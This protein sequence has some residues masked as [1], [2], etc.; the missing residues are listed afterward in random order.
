MNLFEKCGFGPTYTSKYMIVVRSTM[1]PQETGGLQCRRDNGGVFGQLGG[2]GGRAGRESTA[3]INASVGK[4]RVKFVENWSFF[5]AGEAGF[6]YKEVPPRCGVALG[7]GRQKS[8]ASLF[9][10]RLAVK[11]FRGFVCSGM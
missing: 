4:V 3:G 11:A 5:I 2:G 7:C 6:Q 1:I 9:L 8:P 10:M